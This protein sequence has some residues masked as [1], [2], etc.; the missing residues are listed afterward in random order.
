MTLRKVRTHG[1]QNITHH[2]T[3]FT[4]PGDQEPGMC[5]PLYWP[6]V[7]TAYWNFTRRL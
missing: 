3:K 1:P 5:A 4:R 7:S 6:T 2:H